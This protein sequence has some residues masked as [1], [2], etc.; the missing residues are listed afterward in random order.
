MSTTTAETQ[1]AFY[2]STD[3]QVS[4]A[5]HFS[6]TY[7]RNCEV[8]LLIC[9]RK[10]RKSECTGAILPRF[11]KKIRLSRASSPFK[12]FICECEQSEAV[13]RA[14]FLPSR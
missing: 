13:L 8:L 7:R 6:G 12:S 3:F 4:G 14:D 9:G 2:F 10:S 1:D 11:N 5:G